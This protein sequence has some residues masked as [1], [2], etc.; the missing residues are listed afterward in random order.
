[1]KISKTN[2]CDSGYLINVLGELNQYKQKLGQAK[3]VYT[4]GTKYSEANA[5]V[6][7]VLIKVE[8][9]KPLR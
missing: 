7:V 1:M 9:T 2:R 8:I 4:K 5:N 3:C 6:H